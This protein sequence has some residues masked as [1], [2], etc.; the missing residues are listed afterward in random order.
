MIGELGFA[1]FQFQGA[2]GFVQRR[3]IE[4]V[5]GAADGFVGFF[6]RHAVVDDVDHAANG[7]AAVQQG[8]G[9]AQDLDPLGLRGFDAVGMV[10]ADVGHIVV[11]DAVFHDAH[12]RPAQAADDWL[13]DAGTEGLVVDARL[14]AQR[15]ADGRRHLLAQFGI[16][17]YRHRAG[18]AAD[19][20][21]Q[22][23]AFHGDFLQLLNFFSR[24]G[25]C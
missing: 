1:A 10:G 18:Q 13:A 23:L 11:A 16:L 17:Q 25:W 4:L 2:G 14:L 22:R 12:A 15:G 6:I 19:G 9:A 21:F 5:E 20:A 8:G 24:G 3:V 7:A